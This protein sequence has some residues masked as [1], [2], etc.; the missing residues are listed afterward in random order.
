MAGFTTGFSFGAKTA[1]TTAS[2]FSFGKPATAPVSTTAS[3]GFGSNLTTTT[4]APSFGFGTPA[5]TS[6][7]GF[8]VKT[9]TTT[10]PTFSFGGLTAKPTTSA[11]TLNFGTGGTTSLFGSRTT[12]STFSFGPSAATSTTAA[13]SGLGAQVTQSN[14]AL[15]MAA[16]HMPRVFNDERDG[17]L[18]KWN[19]LQAFWGTGKGYVTQ[20][21][22]AS[23]SP[24]N[25]FCYFKAVGYSFMPKTKDEDGLVALITN[26]TLSDL[27]NNQQASVTFLSGLLGNQPTLSV[28]VESVRELPD[29]KT[30]MVIYVQERLPNGSVRKVSAAQLHKALCQGNVSTQLKTAGVEQAIPKA[31]MSASALKYYLETPPAGLDPIL[32]DQA[33]KDNP[34]PENLLPV[35]M[36]GFA[37]VYRRI[38]H[39]EQQCMCHQDRLDVIEGEIKSLQQIHATSMSRIEDYK[40]K[41]L[42][43]SHRVLKVIVQQEIHRKMGYGILAEEE[44]LR[45][46]L[47]AI[48]QELNAPTQF[49]SRLSELLSQIRLQNQTL[50]TTPAEG[51]G[52]LDKIYMAE[53]K[54]H[55]AQQ[56]KGLQELIGIVKDDLADLALIEA[57]Y[58]DAPQR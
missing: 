42:N 15:V 22:S 32:W 35:P 4:A 12:A 47:E 2:A 40:R 30:E 27:E 48:Q 38:K 11:P 56:Q 41:H 23:F 54:A 28:C 14:E 45:I 49:K 25:P 53:I 44:Q 58:A 50:A 36:V 51:Q 52:Q 31:S 7:G 13:S 3:F 57:G 37:E 9:T 5:S 10:A 17:I 46:K 29:K 19:Q 33:K 21:S 18:T 34:D 1:T 8:G 20:N 26:K 39:Q 55:L 43:L 24:E 16:V 6:L